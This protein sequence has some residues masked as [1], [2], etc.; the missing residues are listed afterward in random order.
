MSFLKRGFLCGLLILVALG[1]LASCGGRGNG[2]ETATGK[3]SDSGVKPAPG[4]VV[5]RHLESDCKTL[6]WVLSTTIYEVYVHRYLSD[7]LLDYDQNLEIVPVLAEDY[8]ISKDHLRITVTL[9]DSI[10]WH[11][12]QPI[13]V[14]DVKF[15]VEKILD[16]SVPAVNKEGWFTK[17]DKMEITDDRTIVFVWKEP[18]APSLHALTQL[19]PIP[20]HIYGEGDFLSHPANRKPVGSGAFKFEEWQTS[21]YI[22]LVRN[23]NYHGEPPYLDRVVFKIIPDR[24]VALNALKTGELDEMR[25]RQ[26]QWELQTND[27]DFLKRFNKAHYYVPQYNYLAWNC[28]SIWFEDKRVRRAMTML[29]DREK[30]NSELYS[31]FA[32]IVTG[33]FYI[34]S[35][36]YDSSIE[37]FPFNPVEAKRL[38]DEAGWTD[39]DNDGIRDKDD[40]KFEFDFFITSGNRIGMQYAELLQEECGKVGIVVKIR[41]LE[42]ATFFDRMFKGEYDSCAL[43]WRLEYDPDLYDTFH[44]SQVPPIGLNHT[45]YSNPEVDALLERGRVE[46]DKEKRKEIYHKVHRLIHEDQPYTFVNSVPDKRPI[47]KRIG[48]VVFSPNGPFDFYPGANYWFVKDGKKETD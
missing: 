25:V 19:A 6:N 3:Q 34:N 44:S 27:A 22:S 41:Q 1:P 8:E 37:P 31:G 45:F 33:P 40:L 11:D 26:P 48:N 28:R 43:A 16:P 7:Y 39:H 30:I 2:D 5:F 17:L 24:P 13:T 29:F 10:F 21:R 36:A 23:E 47:N 9:K 14:E 18:Y 42:G 32:K 4:G 15:T 12:G 35:W 46:F 20:K 38:L